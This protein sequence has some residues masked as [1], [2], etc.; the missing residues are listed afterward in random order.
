[1]I[2]SIQHDLAF[3]KQGKDKGL[4]VFKLKWILTHLTIIS[5]TVSLGTETFL[6]TIIFMLL[7]VN[8]GA[9]S[10]QSR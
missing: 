4:S 6:E 2:L 5:H 10:H 1:M 3:K 7:L 8:R 9:N